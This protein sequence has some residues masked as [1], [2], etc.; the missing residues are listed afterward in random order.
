MGARTRIGEGVDIS[1]VCERVIVRVS[2]RRMRKIGGDGGVG[3]GEGTVGVGVG[4]GVG[5][6]GGVGVGGVG[7]GVWVGVGIGGWEGFG[8]RE[9]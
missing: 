4:E 1:R 6:V 5:G 3:G 2:G 7:V 9:V 8:G